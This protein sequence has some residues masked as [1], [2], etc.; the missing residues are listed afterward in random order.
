MIPS[1][2][3]FKKLQ[4]SLLGLACGGLLSGASP[5]YKEV[6]PQGEIRYTD[7]PSQKEA[8]TLDLPPLP[9]YTPPPLPPPTS[10]KPP[11]K[12]P[13]IRQYQ[14]V[15]ITPKADQVFTHEVQEV[16]VKLYIEPALHAQDRIQLRLNDTPYGQLQTQPVFVLKDLERGT[17]QLQ[18]HI[19]QANQQHRVKGQTPILQIHQQRPI[20]RKRF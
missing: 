15:F 20:V 10:S 11:P 19:L 18:A 3:R 9:A 16:Q 8:K 1:S 12:A 5:I 4:A 13:P 2:L 7:S 14:M 6:T 17:Y